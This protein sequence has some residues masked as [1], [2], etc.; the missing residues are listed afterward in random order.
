MLAFFAR[1]TLLGFS[2]HPGPAH[3]DPVEPF[4][5][6]SRCCGVPLD[7]Y[8]AGKLKLDELVSRHMPLEEVNSAFEA[9]SRGEVARSVLL[10]E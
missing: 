2:T 9:L 5:R 8:K 7:L 6:V 1:R 10:F 3:G 4:F